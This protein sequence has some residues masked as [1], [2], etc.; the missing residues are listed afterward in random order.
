VQNENKEVISFMKTLRFHGYS[1]DTFGEYGITNEDVDNCA[2]NKPIQCFIESSEGKLV[3]V[4]HYYIHPTDGCWTVGISQCDEGS[5]IP[6][7]FIRMTESDV[8]YSLC[9]E[10][11]VPDDFKLTWYSNGK[12]VNQ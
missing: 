1:D 6:N 2:A 7:W 5:K 3:V 12:Q 11:D 8:E 10:I 9:L 4:G